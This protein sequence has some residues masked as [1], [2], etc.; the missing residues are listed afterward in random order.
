MTVL[1]YFSRQRQDPVLVAAT[2]GCALDYAST[3]LQLKQCR[4]QVS[5]CRWHRTHVG[6][7]P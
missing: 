4:F 2:I 5:E 1:E 6:F 3:L 7:N